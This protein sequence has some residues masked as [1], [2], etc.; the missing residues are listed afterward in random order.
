MLCQATPSGDARG[1]LRTSENRDRINLRHSVGLTT[2][3]VEGL[4]RIVNDDLVAPI[5]GVFS[6]T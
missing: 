3:V 5:M 2:F 4:I 1:D 6:D